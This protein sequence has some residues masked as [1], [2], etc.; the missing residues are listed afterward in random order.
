MPKTVSF[1]HLQKTPKN[2][3]DAFAP[4]PS[5]DYNTLRIHTVAQ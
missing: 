4:R 3:T 1:E 2:A 5:N